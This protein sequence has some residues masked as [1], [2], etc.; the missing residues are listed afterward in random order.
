MMITKGRIGMTAAEEAA[1][2]FCPRGP[3]DARTHDIRTWHGHATYQ[4]HARAPSGKSGQLAD[5]KDEH[6]IVRQKLLIDVRG[7]DTSDKPDPTTPSRFCSGFS[8]SHLY[9]C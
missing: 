5:Q 3:L 6:A 7:E 2:E 9:D 8:I 4:H 1:L